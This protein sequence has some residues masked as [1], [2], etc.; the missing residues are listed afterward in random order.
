MLAEKF[1]GKANRICPLSS[2]QIMLLN[3]IFDAMV[4]HRIFVKLLVSKPSK[5]SVSVR[6]GL[7]FDFYLNRKRIKCWLAA[8]TCVV[9]TYL[10]IS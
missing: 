7:V 9:V 6:L 1:V 10:H 2:L 3:H 4:L 5:N 8:Y